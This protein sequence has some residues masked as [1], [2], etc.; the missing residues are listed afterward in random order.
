MQSQSC[1]KSERLK[2]ELFK[3]IQFLSS[4]Y[5]VKRVLNYAQKDF[6]NNPTTFVLNVNDAESK[7]WENK[8][9]Q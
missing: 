3:P 2:N 1:H 4:H 9:V 7:A 6:I 8:N 5:S